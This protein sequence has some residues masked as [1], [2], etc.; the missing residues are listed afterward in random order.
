MGAQASASV[1]VRAAVDQL[2]A[3][4]PGCYKTILTILLNIVRQPA[5]AKYR[6][7]RLGNPKIQAA[8][9]NVDGGLELL[10][11]RSWAAQLLPAAPIQ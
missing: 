4:P 1:E 6:K 2:L 7:I 11:A 9:V 5:D 10:Q 3:G 8:V